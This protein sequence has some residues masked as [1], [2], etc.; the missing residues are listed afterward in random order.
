[1]FSVFVEERKESQA[2]KMY[3]KH[4]WKDINATNFGVS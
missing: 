2:V 3:K 4:S 1:M